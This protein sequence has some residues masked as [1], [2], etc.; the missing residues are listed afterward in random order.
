[1]YHPTQRAR[2]NADELKWRSIKAV[3]GNKNLPGPPKGRVEALK[4][5]A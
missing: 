4:K 1:M 2:V 3:T 5:R